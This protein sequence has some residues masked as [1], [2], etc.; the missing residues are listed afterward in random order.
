[1]LLLLTVVKVRR[2]HYAL[3]ACSIVVSSMKVRDRLMRYVDAFKHVKL[4]SR[5]ERTTY[6]PKALGVIKALV[7]A[8]I[9]LSVD[10]TNY[11]IS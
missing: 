4:P 9:P 10:V 8:G 6:F 2:S 1:M 11:L 7:D 5:R 3:I